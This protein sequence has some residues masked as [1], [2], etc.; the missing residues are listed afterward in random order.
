M[1]AYRVAMP[2]GTVATMTGQPGMTLAVVGMV[3]GGWSVFAGFSHF[4][5]ASDEVD[6]LTASF[7]LS[8]VQV[9]PTF[10]S[11]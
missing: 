10:P 1:T 7:N 5:P 2:D 9:V 3:K 11:V 8:Q 4:G 6:Y